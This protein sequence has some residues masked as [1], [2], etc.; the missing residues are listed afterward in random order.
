MLRNPWRFM[1]DITSDWRMAS[2]LLEWALETIV[3]SYAYVLG[4]LPRQPEIIV[5]SDDLGF[6][7]SMFLSP[8]D[9]RTYVRPRF[10]SLLMRLRRLTSASVCFHSCG[11][12]QPIISDI[13]DLG[14]EIINVDT[15]AR[16]M[17]ARQVRQSLPA[18]TVLHGTTDLCALGAAIEN[19]NLAEV[20][21]LITELADSAPVI[22]GPAD[23]LSSSKELFDAVRGTSFVRNLS[24]EDFEALRRLGP[25]RRIIERALE[26]TRSSPA[27]AG[28]HWS[29]HS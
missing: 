10:R 2:A 15:K 19:Q 29:S 26:K 3:E 18:S 22:A 11:A 28:C 21:F 5:Y 14:I 6:Y 20:A 23:S 17:A 13:A 4:K 12:I 8:S 27:L 24:D 7:D 1:D 16:G 9:F 25:V